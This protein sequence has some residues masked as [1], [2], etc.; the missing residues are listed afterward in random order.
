MDFQSKIFLTLDLFV[1]RVS[2]TFSYISSLHT[3]PGQVADDE[4]PKNYTEK[5]NA[6]SKNVCGR[7]QTAWIL[8][9][10]SW[11]TPGR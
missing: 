9:P 5:G 1:C 11:V 7:N 3:I 6:V 10:N 4:Q 2:N 8:T